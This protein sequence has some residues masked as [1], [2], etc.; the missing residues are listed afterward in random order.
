M[1]FVT[2]YIIIHY[3]NLSP[4]QW[5]NNVKAGYF[6]R[7]SFFLLTVNKLICLYNI[8]QYKCYFISVVNANRIV[9]QKNEVFLRIGTV[10]DF[11]YCSCWRWWIQDTKVFTVNWFDYCWI[12]VK[13]AH[14]LLRLVVSISYRHKLCRLKIR[15]HKNLTKK[16]HFLDVYHIIYICEHKI[17]VLK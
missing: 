5:S 11:L 15:L 16:I 8:F 2:V 3:S 4:F 13:N 14:H 10:T 6:S 1:D 17:R 9:R 7:K 12:I